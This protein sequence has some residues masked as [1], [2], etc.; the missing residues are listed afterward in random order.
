MSSVPYGAQYP[1]ELIGG[2]KDQFLD[3]GVD[4]PPYYASK[5][6]SKKCSQLL[7]F[8]KILLAVLFV[9]SLTYAFY[10]HVKV[11]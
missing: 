7:T 4:P 1:I 5:G 11:K 10:L 8:T 3:L 6:R 9:G 2:K